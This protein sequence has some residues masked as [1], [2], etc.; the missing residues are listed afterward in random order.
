MGLS[1]ANAYSYLVGLKTADNQ[2]LRK[3][4][5]MS[6]LDPAYVKPVVQLQNRYTGMP[7]NGKL[8]MLDKYTFLTSTTKDTVVLYID[9]YN[10]S[11]LALPVGFKY[12]Q[13]LK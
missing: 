11:Q 12:E 13:G 9:I 7:I 5:R 10:K 4:F 8:G 1:M 3:I 2:S 6:V